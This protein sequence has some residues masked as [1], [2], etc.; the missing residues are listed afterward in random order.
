MGL[1]IDYAETAFKTIKLTIMKKTFTLLFSSLLSLSLLAFDGSRLSI[2]SPG[3]STEMKI[4]IDGRKFSMKNNSITVSYLAE[5]RHSIKIYKDSKKNK[6]GFGRKEEVIYQSG[7][8]L[9]RGFHLDITVNRFGKV[10]T[11][12]RRID[13]DD[14]FFQEEDDYYDSDN[15]GWSGPNIN[16]MSTKEFESVKESLRREWFENNRIV[17]VKTIADKSN[18]TTRQVKELML[19]FTFEDNR[20]EVAKYAYRKTVDK[21]NYYDLSDA[22]TF[23]SS[24]NELARFIRE[25][26]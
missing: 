18:F 19:L 14:E 7:I 26:R 15:G 2:S 13:R 21:Q 25:S 9:K 16:V 17:S 5:G 10:M 23:T 8:F 12:E 20:L 11:D 22:L 1:E 6:Y 4:E 24:K 3:T